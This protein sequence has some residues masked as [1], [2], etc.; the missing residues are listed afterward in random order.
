MRYA[1]IAAG[2]GSRL[3]QEG[4]EVQKP[5]VKIHGETL[6]DRLVR[7]FSDNDAEDIVVALRDCATR[8][9]TPT[10]R[11]LSTILCHTPSSMHTFHALAPRLRGS[12]AFV[13]TT[14][15]TVFRENEFAGYVGVFRDALADGYD[16]VMGVTDYIDDEKPLY[17]GVDGDDN[18]TGF[19]D[20]QDSCRYISAGIYGLSEKALDTLDGCIERGES[21]MR[22]FQRALLRDGCRLKAW[23]FS[24]VIDVDHVSDIAKAEELCAG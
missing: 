22:N 15:D 3:A 16:G 5:F 11:H 24:K 4:M 19:Y 14:V 20:E 6:M 10:T 1:I 12:G 23:R 18:I 9:S 2:E 17:V 8:H 7:I 21:R 13:L